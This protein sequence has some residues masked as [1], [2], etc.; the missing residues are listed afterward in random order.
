[1]WGTWVGKLHKWVGLFLHNFSGS[2]KKRRHMPCACAF[3]APWPLPGPPAAR[4]KGCRLRRNTEAGSGVCCIFSWF[5]TRLVDSQP[6]QPVVSETCVS[7]K[8]HMFHHFCSPGVF[9]QVF[10][11][12]TGPVGFL[13]IFRKEWEVTAR[14][15]PYLFPMLFLRQSRYQPTCI[16]ECPSK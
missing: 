9:N 3:G 2:Q 4:K 8:V 11:A 6:V 14:L 1:M 16:E 15:V 7:T 5:D 13:G 12:Q 10:C